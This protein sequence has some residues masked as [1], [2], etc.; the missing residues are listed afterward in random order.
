MRDRLSAM[1]TADGLAYLTQDEPGI[2]GVIKARPEDFVVTEAPLYDPCGEGEHLYLYI[3]KRRR[4]T[5]DIVRFLS[6]HF[7]VA[8]DAIGYGGLKDKHAVTRQWFSVHFGK[9][10]RAG[11]FENDAVKILAMD[12]HT[13][14]I[15]RGH[16]YGNRFEIKIR[17]VEPTAAVRARRILDRV[18][19]C[20]APNFIGE[21]RFGYRKDTHLQGRALL[22]GELQEF[23]DQMLGRPQA[24]EPERNQEARRLYEAG[25]YKQALQQWAT[26]HRFERQA[27]GPLSRGA[28]IHDAINGIDKPH[29][30]LMISAFQSS[31]FNQLLNDRLL[32]GRMGQLELGD[33]AM[34]HDTRG[35]FEVRDVEAEQPRADRLEISPTGPMWGYHMKR[36]GG[37]V[38]QREAE[39]LADTGV[40]QEELG[41][42]TYTAYGSRRAF[43]MPVYDPE[44]TGGADDLGPYVYLG[45]LLPRGSF[46]TVVLREITKA[47]A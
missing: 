41:E 8:W 23:L 33:L 3:E 7:K 19:Q 22:K 27:I 14:K 28:P 4:L 35:V 43:R 21:Q 40:T 10:E 31:I 6:Q 15:K 20:G 32:A 25:E 30:Q 44:V 24:T 42:G 34:K 46:A 37:A 38:A 45:F 2:G 18:V 1:L 11:E 16:L 29:R 12:R 39:A 47:D 36:A 5:T 26:V 13:N 9:E 17:E